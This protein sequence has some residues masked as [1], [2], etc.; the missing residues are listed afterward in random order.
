[1]LLFSVALKRLK[2]FLRSFF[3]SNFYF[4]RQE[5]E[6]N[7]DLKIQVHCL[8]MRTVI[9]S[10]QNIRLQ[11]FVKVHSVFYVILIRQERHNQSE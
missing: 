6:K 9:V 1:M 5:E 8:Q 2:R 3:V 4:T 7:E 11:G 10:Q